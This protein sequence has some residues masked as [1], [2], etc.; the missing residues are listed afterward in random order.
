MTK[1][2]VTDRKI[3]NFENLIWKMDKLFVFFSFTNNLV[4]KIMKTIVKKSMDASVNEKNVKLKIFAIFNPTYTNGR[5][6]SPIT[7]K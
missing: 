3:T 6:E 1:P 4:P 7:N 5:I 2:A